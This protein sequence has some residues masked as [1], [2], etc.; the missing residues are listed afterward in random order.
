MRFSFVWFDGPYWVRPEAYRNDR[1][2]LIPRHHR[3]SRIEL[4]PK[5]QHLPKLQRG[6]RG[7]GSEKL[8][9]PEAM[10]VDSQLS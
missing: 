1:A 7:L 8:D 6:P 10:P 9:G 2:V 4:E 3:Q 5:F